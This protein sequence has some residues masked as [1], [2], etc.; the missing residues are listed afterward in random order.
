MG[1]RK[2]VKTFEE[3]LSRLE[4]ISN[5]LESGEIGLEESI[6]LFKEGVKIS[7][8][9][10][11]TLKKAEVKITELKNDLESVEPDW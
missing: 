5:L 3:N 2:S 6:E 11:S 9:C 7:K 10:I 8:E 4:E 1:K